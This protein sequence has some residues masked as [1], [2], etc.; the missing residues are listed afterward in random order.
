MSEHT[1][2]SQPEAFCQVRDAG[3]RCGKL[4]THFVDVDGKAFRICDTCKPPASSREDIYRKALRQIARDSTS[5][6]DELQDMAR[7]ALDEGGETLA[8]ESIEDAYKRLVRRVFIPQRPNV[9]VSD[10]SRITGLSW[11]KVNETITAL[12]EEV[13]HLEGKFFQLR[14]GIR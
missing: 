11:A 12:G 9:S 14:K 3:W 4:G 8:E 6:L 5:D 1:E 2:W 10:I 13:E 7:F